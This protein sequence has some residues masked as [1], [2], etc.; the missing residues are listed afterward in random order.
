MA[1]EAEAGHGQSSAQERP[2]AHL[3]AT[4]EECARIV[5]AVPFDI[6]R[7]QRDVVPPTNEELTDLE[8]FLRERE[9]MRRHSLGRARERLAELF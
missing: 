6:D 7:W 3:Q 4:P 1:S 9:E 2:F 8:E 5:A